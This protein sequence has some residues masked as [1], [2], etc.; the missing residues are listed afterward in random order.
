VSIRRGRRGEEEERRMARVEGSIGRGWAA[1]EGMGEEAERFGE[2]L[3]G[4]E[5][6]DSDKGV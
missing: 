4:G 2:A 3:K 5:R 1:G 6:R